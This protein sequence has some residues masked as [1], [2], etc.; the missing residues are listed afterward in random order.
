MGKSLHIHLVVIDPQN[1]F[2][3]NDDGSPYSVSFKDGTALAAT[4]AVKGAVSDMK[5]LAA[6]IDRVGPRLADVHV[7]LD[8]HRVI[9]VAHPGMWRDDAGRPPAPFTIIR[10]DDIKSAI[11]QP[12]NFAHRKRML[13]YAAALETTGKYLLIIWPEHCLIG[14]WGHNVEANLAAA[15]SRWERT[16][17]ANVD[18]V[19][20]GSN[21]FTEHYGAL[22]A[23][24]PDPEDPSTQLNMDFIKILEEADIVGVAGEASS[25][26]VKETIGQVVA[27]IGPDH[28]KKFHILTDCMSPVPAAPGTPDFPAIAEQFLKDMAGCGMVLT[29]SDKFLR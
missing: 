19:T 7:T 15:L 3:G 21:P 17:F 27:N 9:D 12:R 18:Y 16:Q 4:L 20:K 13:D 24:V 26:C 25:H 6:M 8:S 14:S 29:T 2:M 10:H 11:W 23:E 1:D 22:M 5:R 28:L